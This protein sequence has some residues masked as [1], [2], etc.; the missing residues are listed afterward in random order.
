[1]TRIGRRVGDILGV[2]YTY[3]IFYERTTATCFVT[4]LSERIVL[5][6]RKTL[7]A[8]VDEVYIILISA[9]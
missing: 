3:C 1:M 5:F 2:V 4:T 6:E 8:L 9:L 7:Y